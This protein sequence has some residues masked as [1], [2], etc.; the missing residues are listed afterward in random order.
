MKLYVYRRFSGDNESIN[1]GKREKRRESQTNNGSTYSVGVA[2][3]F[4]EVVVYT[5]D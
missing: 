2:G 4:P 5:I 3:S 1:L